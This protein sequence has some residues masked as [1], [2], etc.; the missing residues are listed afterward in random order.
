M[1]QMSETTFQFGDRVRH[2]KRPEW[3]IGSVI[4]TEQTNVAGR[5]TQRVSV[6]F[7]NAGLKTLSTQHAEL[8]RVD[9][10]DASSIVADRPTVE[11]LDRMKGADWLAPMAER[12][13]EALMIGLPDE[14]TDRFRPLRARLEYTLRL[15]RFEKHGGSLIEWAVAQSGLDD[16]LT[17]FARQELEQLFDRWTYERDDHLRQLLLEARGEPALVRE[18]V[19]E[20][21]SAAKS[22]VQR[23]T[24]QR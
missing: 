3:G 5:A 15:Y 24:A 18:L 7:P 21:S 6:R 22:A 19:R 13:V 12:K 20:S 14:A 17:R 11:S 8:E 23:I 9:G 16:P 2:A 10:Q 1:Q 4:K